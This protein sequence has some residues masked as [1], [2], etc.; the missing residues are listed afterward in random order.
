MEQPSVEIDFCLFINFSFGAASPRGLRLLFFTAMCEK[1]ATFRH[2]RSAKYSN[3]LNLLPLKLSSP[4]YCFSNAFAARIIFH[5]V[6]VRQSA[7]KL[8]V[9]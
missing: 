1:N 3:S 6:K 7:V 9:C 8:I 2:F 4:N 5:P